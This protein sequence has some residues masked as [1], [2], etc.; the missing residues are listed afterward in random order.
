MEE[1]YALADKCARM[2][3]GWRAPELAV[4]A[5]LAGSTVPQK[6]SSRKRSLPPNPITEGIT[7]PVMTAWCPIHEVP[8]TRVTATLCAALP[9]PERSGMRRGRPVYRPEAASPAGSRGT[10]S[11]TARPG[12]PEERRMAETRADA[13]AGGSLHSKRK[14]KTTIL[15]PTHGKQYAY[16]RSTAPTVVIFLY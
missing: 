8:M 1:L 12:L 15:T 2:E 13:Q 3:E 14:R 5:A 10:A 16:S 6:G 11:G 4:E 9:L 7:P